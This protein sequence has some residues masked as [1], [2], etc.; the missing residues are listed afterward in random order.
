MTLYFRTDAA[1]SSNTS[2]SISQPESS[3]TGHSPAQPPA[4]YERVV[5]LDMKKKNSS[6]ILAQFMSLSGATPVQ[7]TPEE[8]EQ[9]KQMAELVREGEISREKTR[10]RMEEIK[11]EE[12]MLKKA[13]AGVA[14]LT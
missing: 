12:D 6:E 10:R 9:L 3:L 1:T 2:E 4:S 8:N 11:R 5:K 14:N 7:P 13:R